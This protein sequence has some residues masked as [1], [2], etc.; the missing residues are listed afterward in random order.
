MKTFKTFL[1]KESFWHNENAK[2][3]VLYNKDDALEH[4][5]NLSNSQTTAEKNHI[6]NKL[7]NVRK[8]IENA[9]YKS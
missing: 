8:A 3:E 2:H 5:K 9:T 4:A 7:T 6:S 1:M